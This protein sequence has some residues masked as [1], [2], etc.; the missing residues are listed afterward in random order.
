ME[1]DNVTG[2]KSEED[3]DPHV[4]KTTHSTCPNFVKESMA[5]LISTTGILNV[6]ST[7][8][9]SYI[10]LVSAVPKNRAPKRVVNRMGKGKGQTFGADEEDFI[11]MKRKKS[12]GN[13]GGNKNIK[14]VSVK[15]KPLYHPKAKQS[16]EGTSNSPKTTHVVGTNMASTSGFNL[17]YTTSSSN[18]VIEEVTTGD[19]AI[20]S[21]TQKE[22]KSYTR[23]VERINVFE[24]Q[25]LE[26]KLVFVDDYGKPLEKVD[27]SGNTGSEDEVEHVDIETA[28]YVASK[29][30]GVGYDTK[31][32]LKK[33]RKTVVDDDYGSYDDDMYKG[34]EI[35]ENIH[36]ICDILDIKGK[37]VL[38]DDDGKPLE[39]VD[40]S[41]N[42]GSEDEVEHVDNETASYVA[43]KLMGVGYGTKSLLKQ[44]RET[45]IDDDYGSYDDGMY[46]G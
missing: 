1:N 43:S 33:S 38:V 22:G 18:K 3:T 16:S 4:L 42:T 23:L 45:V 30:M 35:P 32:L 37:P 40:Y 28:S 20:T 8:P 31:S 2:S 12:G 24:K 11:E 15:P 10:N 44:S 26:G 19:K 14:P 17:E 34:Q 25:M 36:T 39:K 41:G 6:L 5:G 27:Y 21:G 46:K 29:L 13:N 9:V 7:R